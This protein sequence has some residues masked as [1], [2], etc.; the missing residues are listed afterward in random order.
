MNGWN[1][2]ALMKAISQCRDP[3]GIV[4]RCPVFEIY[5]PQQYGTCTKEDE[6][7][8]QGPLKILP[9]CNIVTSGPEN[10]PKGNC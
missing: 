5:T 9:G 4:D 3:S 7:Q 10:A 6:A 1:Q 8:L 2:T